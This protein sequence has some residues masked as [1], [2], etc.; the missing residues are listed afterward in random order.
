LTRFRADNPGVWVF[1]CHLEW[2]LQMGLVANFIEQPQVVS[3]F[4]L[5][6]AVDDLCDGPQVPIF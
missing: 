5:P 6:M 2:H 4:V 1:H 3:S